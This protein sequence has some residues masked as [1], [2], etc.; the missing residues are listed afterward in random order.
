M[1]A[2]LIVGNLKLFRGFD[3]LFNQLEG[4]LWIIVQTN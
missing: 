1:A 4:S 3:C 2:F